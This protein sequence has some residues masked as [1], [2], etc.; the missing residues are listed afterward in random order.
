M[1]RQQRITMV[2]VVALLA[3]T[4]CAAPAPQPDAEAK[5]AVQALI[6]RAID[7][8]NHQVVTGFSST[9]EE[10]SQDFVPDAVERI[11]LEYGQLHQR[12]DAIAPHG[13][14]LTDSGSEITIKKFTI[15]DAGAN[16]EISEQT[17]LEHGPVNG[18]QGPGEGYVY[19]QKV[20]LAKSGE[21]WKIVQ[22]LPSQAGQALPDDNC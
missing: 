22:Y 3:V 16:I 11:E 12:R 15:T 5:A 7:R 17:Q 4:S 8:R 19:D 10:I 6:E 20:E 14:L 1:T 21:G 9:K 18:V 2:A 13:V